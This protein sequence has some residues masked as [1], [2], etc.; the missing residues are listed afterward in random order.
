MAFSSS[1]H[2]QTDGQTEVLNCGLETY[3]RCFVSK[4]PQ[5]WTR[6]L[7]LAEIWYNTSHH[8]AI[9]VTPFEA[10]Y[11]RAPPS[12]TDY[13][14]GS[15]TIAT[16]DAMQTKRSQTLE[17]LKHN[18]TRAS[19]HMVQQ[20]NSNRKD[21]KFSAGDWVYLKLQPYRQ[22]PVHCRVSKKLAKRYYGPFRILKRI[23][24]VAYELDLPATA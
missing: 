2:P 4:E 3:L 16:L 6:F 20:A 21:T 7:S 17:L 15:S 11:G 22:I 1:Y 24:S 19:H 10:L 12:L 13:I 14:V 9:G 5:Q 8:S 18:L 23:G